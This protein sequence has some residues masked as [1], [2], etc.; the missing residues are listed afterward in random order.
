MATND[1]NSSRHVFAAL[2]IAIF[3]AFV[4]TGMHLAT[5]IAFRD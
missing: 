1:S 4:Q 3:Y 5:P 2:L